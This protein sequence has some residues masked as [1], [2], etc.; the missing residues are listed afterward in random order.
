MD[1]VSISVRGIQAAATSGDR[2]ANDVANLTTPGFR[3][4]GAG[5]GAPAGIRLPFVPAP[6]L[7]TPDGFSLEIRGN[8]FFRVSTPRG[9]RFTAS[10]WFHID[11]A[12]NLVTIGGL[13]LSP[14][15][16][17][18]LDAES[19]LV[20]RDGRVMAVFADGSETQVGQL[21]T[22]SFPNPGGLLQ[23]AGTL[24]A[25]GP[26]SGSA[27]PVPPSQVVFGGLRGSGVDPAKEGVN[28]LQDRAALQANVVAV[29]L[30]DQVGGSL[31]DI[32]S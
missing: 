14:P 18:P 17:F 12:G 1:G 5:P 21:Q 27:V 31:L 25:P 6:V 29:H 30:Q 22:F 8:A 2:V 19:L 4:S 10:G 7:L 24:E 26:A 32:L 20:M 16:N 11:A 23:E 15:I 9:P 13:P 3:P 28:A